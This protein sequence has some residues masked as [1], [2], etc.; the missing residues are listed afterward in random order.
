MKTIKVHTCLKVDSF[1]VDIY[2][3]RC[4]V[5][6]ILETFKAGSL[7]S[8]LK[9][10]GLAESLYSIGKYIEI[11]NDGDPEQAERK[12]CFSGPYF[13]DL[14]DGHCLSFQELEDLSLDHSAILTQ[15]IEAKAESG[16]ILIDS[17]F[18]GLW[19]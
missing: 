11:H 7:Y 2:D 3:F 19:N 8:D 5:R 1:E 16:T 15:L 4:L 12:G 9:A 14:T 13:Y 17:G 6:E 18:S 10:D